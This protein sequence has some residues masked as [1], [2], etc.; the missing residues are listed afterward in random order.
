MDYSQL[1]ILPEALCIYFVALY[2]G[3]RLGKIIFS[4]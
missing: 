3:K 4:K 1:I 2:V